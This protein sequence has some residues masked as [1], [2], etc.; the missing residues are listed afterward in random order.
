[1]TDEMDRQNWRKAFQK[2]G[3]EQLRLRLEHRRNEY[4]G[5]YGLEAERWLL[6]QSEK[7]AAIEHGRFRT[8]RF[9]S[10]IGGVAG[11][12]AA[13]AAWIAAWPVIASWIWK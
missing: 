9:W 11:V 12:L 13:I 6:E 1:M 3:P 10:I 5:E 8:I 4:T 2:I 7:S